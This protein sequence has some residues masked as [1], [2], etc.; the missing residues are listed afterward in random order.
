MDEKFENIC[1]FYSTIHK[2]KTLLRTGWLEWN[3]NADR[4][5]SVAEHIYGTQ[6]LA[7]AVNSEFNLGLDIEKVVYMLAFHEIGE[8]IIGDVTPVDGVPREVKHEVERRAVQKVLETLESGAEILKLFDEFEANQTKEAIFA[9][10]ID[11]FEANFQMKYYE[12]SGCTDINKA[13]IEAKELMKQKEFKDE[14]SLA[15][16]WIKKYV[17]RELSEESKDKAF[18]EL[19]EFIRTNS[20]FKNE[21]NIE[22]LE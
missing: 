22:D 10:I 21:T 16:L 20:I 11:H 6:M 7:F 17:K 14:K 12:E 1:K 9:E 13:G 8:A 2:L 19:A 18:T 3:V 4:F 15:N 5:E